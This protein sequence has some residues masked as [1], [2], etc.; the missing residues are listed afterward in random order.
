M[1]LVLGYD[2]DS[3]VV[4]CVGMLRVRVVLHSEVGSMRF[5]VGFLCGIGFLVFAG[6]I[7]QGISRVTGCGIGV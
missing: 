5:F 3:G 2:R 1:S 4:C 6:Q 7:M